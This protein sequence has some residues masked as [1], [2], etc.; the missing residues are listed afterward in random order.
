MEVFHYSCGIQ[1]RLNIISMCCI[2]S[3]WTWGLSIA[4]SR[5]FGINKPKLKFQARDIPNDKANVVILIVV[6]MRT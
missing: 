1:Q 2:L 5:S 3:H 6:Q 4:N